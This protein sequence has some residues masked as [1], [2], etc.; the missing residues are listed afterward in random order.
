VQIACDTAARGCARMAAIEPKA[1][2]DTE[3]T[4][5]QVQQRIAATITWLQSFTPAQLDGCEE[6]EVVHRTRAG[7]I[8]YRGLD[9]LRDYALPNFHFHLTTAYAILRVAGTP[10]GKRDYLG[11][12]R[13]DR[14][15]PSSNRY[16]AR[17]LVNANVQS[18][19]HAG[20]S[21]WTHLLSDP[22]TRTAAVVDPVLDF[23]LSSGRVGHESARAVLDAARAAGL[24]I[25]WILETHAHADHLTAADWLR[26]A[27]AAEGRRVPIGVGARIVEVQRHF[28]RVF[29]LE[30]ALV[31]DGSQFDRLFADGER[32]ALGALEVRV[33]ATP[34]HT[35][36]SLSYLVGDAVFVGDTLFAPSR[37]TARCDF[38]G[39][40]A[41]T[42][43][44]S[45]QRLYALPD[46]TRVFL[47]HDY[48]AAGS[49]PG[50]V[51][52]IAA[53][54]SAN[55]QLN[56][57]IREADYVA[58]RTRRDA[59][60]AVPRL[61]HPALQVNIRAGALPPADSEGRRFLRLPV[62]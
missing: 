48:P 4:L 21:T 38:P 55:V 3:T 47:C 11:P 53:Q 25:D 7:D 45:I 10:I 28:R 56:A 37:G 24:R 52:T 2:P 15:I 51:T 8:H 41:A 50:C 57:A 19:F 6:R 12:Q 61:L 59:T 36:D 16:R 5:E 30:D 22:A 20:T 29:A 39:G 42:L 43:Y 33:L 26:G 9:Y 27:L 62:A 60:L 32:F 58:M 13:S 40:D 14:R 44:R 46:T 34:G 23:D 31:A 1:F 35:P 18:F 49:E 17:R 54:K